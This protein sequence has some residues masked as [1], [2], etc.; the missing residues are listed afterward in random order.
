MGIKFIN[1]IRFPGSEF[2]NKW[3]S[4]TVSEFFLFKQTEVFE[5]SH[6]ICAYSFIIY[7]YSTILIPNEQT[8]FL[9]GC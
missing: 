4:V 8:V 5:D 9:K 6:P 7:T 2:Y 3:N 1:K